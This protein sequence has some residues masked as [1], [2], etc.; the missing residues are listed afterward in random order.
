VVIPD[1]LSNHSPSFCL[2]AKKDHNLIHI[3][4]RS[5]FLCSQPAQ[6]SEDNIQSSISTRIFNLLLFYL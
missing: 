6:R 1:S 4:S 3:R 2:G 5:A